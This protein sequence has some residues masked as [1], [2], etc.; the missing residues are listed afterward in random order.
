MGVGGL[1]SVDDA[2]H[3]IP[4]NT[5]IIDTDVT[6]Y[7]PY[8][9]I[10]DQLH[11]SHM[12][13]EWI[14]TYQRIVDLRINAKRNGDKL[15]ANALKIVIN[16]TF[17]KLGSRYSPFYDPTLMTRVTT[18]GQIALLMLIE[19][20]YL[21]DIEVI[22]ANTDGVTVE[23]KEGQEALF[24]ECK[25]NWM[26]YTQFNLEDSEYKQILRRDINSYIAET[27]DGDLKLKG[28]FAE[29]ALK[30]DV[31]AFA[32][33]KMLIANLTQGLPPEEAID[34]LD[35]NIFDFMYSYSATSAFKVSL[36]DQPLT[37]S[38][39]WYISNDNE[40]QLTKFGGKN[41]ITIRIPNG[42]NV[43]LANLV[44]DTA[45]PLNLDTQHYINEANTLLT[46][47]KGSSTNDQLSPNTHPTKH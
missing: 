6:S 27:V 8:I 35:L 24:E 1:H 45:I 42:T 15:I 3:I 9:L 21:N 32:I 2:R 44:T 29:P 30:K 31:Q 37:A 5:R 39:R 46:K 19:E 41:K 14:Q 28:R 47:L 40:N 23:L 20:F 38:N 34:Q 11:P 22:S 10:R 7:Y 36:G 25:R 17:G 4:N 13:L 12:G 33:T 26:D 43:E 18:T 16:A